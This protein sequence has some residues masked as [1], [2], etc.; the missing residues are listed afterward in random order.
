MRN[1]I[2]QTARDLRKNQTGAEA[3]LWEKIRN[4]KLAGKKFLRQHPIVFRWNRRKRFLF[5]DFY[6]AEA[7]LVIELDGGIHHKQ[8]DYDDARDQAMKVLGLTV[9]RFS[10]NEIENDIRGVLEGVKSKLIP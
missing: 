8:K 6:C 7:H 10:N 1:L 5:A 3:I 4:R 2:K 9:M